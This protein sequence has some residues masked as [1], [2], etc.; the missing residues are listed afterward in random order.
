MPL[1]KAK[2]DLADRKDQ[3][4][5]SDFSKAA[6]I[7]KEAEETLDDVKDA[8]NA[9]NYDLAETLCKKVHR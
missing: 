1:K 6:G 4:S 5:K 9:G 2:K 8:I 7:L 3:F